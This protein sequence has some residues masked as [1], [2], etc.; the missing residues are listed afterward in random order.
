LPGSSKRTLSL[1]LPHHNTVFTSSLPHIL[2]APPI[3][4]FSI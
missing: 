1:R 3:L 4:I 2:H